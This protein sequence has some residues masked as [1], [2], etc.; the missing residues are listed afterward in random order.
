MGS[1][2]QSRGECALLQRVWAAVGS[3]LEPLGNAPRG[4]LG[5]RGPV[6]LR[7]SSAPALPPLASYSS[8]VLGGA[9]HLLGAWAPRGM[10]AHCSLKPE[11]P[12]S[13]TAPPPPGGSFVKMSSERQPSHT[14]QLRTLRRP[15]GAGQRHP[16]YKSHGAARNTNTWS[17]LTAHPGLLNGHTPV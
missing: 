4:D 8:L 7:C 1:G 11:G 15:S 2:P 16:Y 12:P 5:L 3:A 10:S 14:F 9:S 17:V 13:G 6:P